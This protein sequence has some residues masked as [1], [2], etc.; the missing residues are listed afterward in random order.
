MEQNEKQQGKAKKAESLAKRKERRRY[1][2]RMQLR[3]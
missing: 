2:K 3:D 1:Y